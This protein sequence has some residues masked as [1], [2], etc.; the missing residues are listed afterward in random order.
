MPASQP[1]PKA[2]PYEPEASTVS[3]AKEDQYLAAE[4]RQLVA[5][6]NERIRLA[7]RNGMC[8]DLELREPTYR[9]GIKTMALENPTIYRP[10]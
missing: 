1:L 5:D 2:R 4:I 6:L 8:V 9:E 10:L 3:K 7:T